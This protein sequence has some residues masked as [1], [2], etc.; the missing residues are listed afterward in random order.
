MTREEAV[1]SFTIWGAYSMFGE[2]IKGSLEAGKLADFVVI[3]RDVMTC[4]DWELMNIQALT[5]VLGGKI[6]YQRNSKTPMVSFQGVPVTFNRKPYLEE[7]VLYAPL[8]DMTNALSATVKGSGKNKAKITY[9]EKSITLPTVKKNGVEYVKV[10]SLYKGL[11]F[12]TQWQKLSKTM[13]IGA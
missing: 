1:R 11:G 12:K 2:N 10:T 8:K 9:K 4:P 13:S 6:T 3:D 7:G 5:T